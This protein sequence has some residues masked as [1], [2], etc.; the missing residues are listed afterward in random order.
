MLILLSSASVM[1]VSKNKLETKIV[2]VGATWC[3]ACNYAKPFIDQFKKAH[4]NITF[5]VYYFDKLNEEDKQKLFAT[6]EI[7]TSIPKYFFI[8]DG[9]KIA[10]VGGALNKKQLTCLYQKFIKLNKNHS[11]CKSMDSRYIF[12]Y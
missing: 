6:Y 3:G 10:R 2:Y 1:A 5:K 9:K 4:T 8:R 7:G 11:T 12:L